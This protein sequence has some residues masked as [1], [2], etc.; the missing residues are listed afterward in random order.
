MRP[1]NSYERRMLI[2][3]GL[4]EALLSNVRMVGEEKVEPPDFEKMA[5]DFEKEIQRDSIFQKE[6]SWERANSNA[7]FYA[8][9]VEKNK[10][11]KKKK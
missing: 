10:K 3:L 2:S 8:K 11:G 5:L 6:T 7:P 1:P 9:F 4:S